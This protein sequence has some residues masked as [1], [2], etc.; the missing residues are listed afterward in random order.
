MAFAEVRDQD[1]VEIEAML[2]L[3]V[4]AL[5]LRRCHKYSVRTQFANATSHLLPAGLG[6]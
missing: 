2:G 6:G 4:S 1:A 3:D 5:Q